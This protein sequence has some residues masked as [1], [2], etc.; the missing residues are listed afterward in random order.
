MWITKLFL[1]WFSK[2]F[3]KFVSQY[4]ILILVDDNELYI[5]L[6]L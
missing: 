3:I 6:K 1:S 2:V 4:T 5:N